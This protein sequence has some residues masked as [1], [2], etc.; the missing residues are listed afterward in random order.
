MDELPLILRAWRTP[1][2][3]PSEQLESAALKQ[4]R[5]H[6]PL[7]DL[8]APVH[9]RTSGGF[10]GSFTRRS[11]ELCLIRGIIFLISW[12]ALTRTI[13]NRFPGGRDGCT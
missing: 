8:P 6:F 1:S 7:A 4:R 2:S 10:E 9:K 12:T 11:N 5:Q 3:E 13:R